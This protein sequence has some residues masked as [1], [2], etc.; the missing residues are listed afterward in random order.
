MG[1]STSV[2]ILLAT[3]ITTKLNHEGLWD[4]IKMCFTESRSY[5][6]R[7]GKSLED[8]FGE[9]TSSHK[10]KEQQ[11]DPDQESTYWI[12]LFYHVPCN[13][14]SRDDICGLPAQ[15]IAFFENRH[16]VFF[17]MHIRVES[18]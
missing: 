15:E 13:K 7:V 3:K 11:E 4:E 12:G 16:N 9:N 2:K 8:L 10:T 14:E 5:N 6:I 17:D 18:S 1:W